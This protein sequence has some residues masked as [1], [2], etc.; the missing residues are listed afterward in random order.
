[1]WSRIGSRLNLK[2]SGQRHTDSLVMTVTLRSTV[3]FQ[4]IPPGWSFRARR[5]TSTPATSRCASPIADAFPHICFTFKINWSS[6][7]GVCVSQMAPPVSGACLRYVAAQGPLP[8][9]CT[10][11]WQ[12][13]WEQ[14]IHTI[15]M[16]TTLTERGRVCILH[17]TCF[18]NVYQD[19]AYIVAAWVYARFGGNGGARKS[20][21]VTVMTN[22]GR[23]L[24]CERADNEVDD[25]STQTEAVGYQGL[26]KWHCFSL[27]LPVAW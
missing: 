19:I 23:K 20:L 26:A 1:M 11:F 6:P 9:T 8:Q 17:V 25:R 27:R 14:Q 3:S 18:W 2:C 10:H 24:E 5:T 4:M 13:V 21:N 15:I 12:T 22:E 16:L 7:W